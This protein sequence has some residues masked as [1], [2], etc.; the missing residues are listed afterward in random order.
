MRRK[1]ASAVEGCWYNRLKVVPG[2]L[3]RYSKDARVETDILKV[4]RSQV[5]SCYLFIIFRDSVESLEP[6]EPRVA[7]C[8]DVAAHGPHSS[9][10]EIP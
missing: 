10:R 1:M 3:S 7:W 5:A 8:L 4:S 2:S 9:P 6:L